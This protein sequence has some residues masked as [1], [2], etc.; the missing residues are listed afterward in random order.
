MVL[1][2]HNGSPNLWSSHLIADTPIC[3]NGAES[4]RCLVAVMSSL[5][6]VLS[7]DGLVSGALE[8]S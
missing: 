4:R 1:S 2:E 6:A 3:A 8:R 5:S 7:A